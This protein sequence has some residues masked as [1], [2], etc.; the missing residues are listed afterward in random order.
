MHRP[1]VGGPGVGTMVPGR[2]AG[3][4][5]RQWGPAS[6]GLEAGGGRGACLGASLP[7]RV[8]CSRCQQDP[9]GVRASGSSSA[10]L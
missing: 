2:E 1:E 9:S 4:V 7:I 5:Q 3:Q 8:L 10:S 6:A